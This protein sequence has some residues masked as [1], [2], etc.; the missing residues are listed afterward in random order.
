MG[1]LVSQIVPALVQD[2]PRRPLPEDV[3]VPD[4]G[5][6]AEG[7]EAGEAAPPEGVAHVAEDHD[8]QKQ[9]EDGTQNHDCLFGGA[10]Y[11]CVIKCRVARKL[12]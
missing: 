2:L 3:G 4:H 11:Y 12:K 9:Q 7:R 5:E 1:N 6:A 10:T 8:G